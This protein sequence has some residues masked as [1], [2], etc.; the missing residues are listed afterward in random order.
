MDRNQN[1]IFSIHAYDRWNGKDIGQY[2]DTLD[3]KDIPAIVG[4]YGFENAGQST[5]DATNR[6][7][8]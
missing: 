3:I 4:E 5:L 7:I 6:A 8:A 2:F 1:I